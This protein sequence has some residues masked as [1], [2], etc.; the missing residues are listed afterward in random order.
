[1][2]VL[3]IGNSGGGLSAKHF[4]AGFARVS[5]F[6]LQTG[7]EYVVYGISLWKGLL[8]YLI[9]GEGLHPH[10]Y[11]SELFRLIRTELPPDSYFAYFGD[12]DGAELSAIWGYHELVNTDGH[13]DDLSNLK[14]EAIEIFMA[15][16]KQIDE[17]S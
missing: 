4:Q 7:K 5:D 15:R 1:M 8:L 16:K 12:R 3:C 10:W 6:D 11:P 9:F 13:F 2:R 17:A 14:D